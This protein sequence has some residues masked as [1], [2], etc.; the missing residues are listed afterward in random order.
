MPNAVRFAILTYR[1][2]INDLQVADA[3]AAAAAMRTQMDVFTAA[4]GAEFEE[5][6]ASLKPKQIDA[7][8][9]T[10]G[11]LLNNN[12]VQLAILAARH[13]IPA[14]FPSREFT[15]A[16]GLMSYGPS[17]T[18]E[19]RQ[20]GIYT[21]RILKGEKPAD[22]PVYRAVKFE[23]VINLKTAKTLGLEFPPA[24]LALADEVIE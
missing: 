21:G 14:M 24:L 19:F 3:K 6:F 4:S 10:P 1:K 15:N 16:G 2:P 7:L 9:V 23:F 20:A 8:L 22:L 17:V 13:A 18:D 11:P 5:I 12:R